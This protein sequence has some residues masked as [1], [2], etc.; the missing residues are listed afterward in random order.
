VVAINHC[1]W[2]RW[3]RGRIG[4]GFPCGHQQCCVRVTAPGF[5]RYAVWKWSCC[6]GGPGS[7]TLVQQRC[8]R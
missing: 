8:R 1:D 5:P 7:R 2:H 6:P 4:M 3:I